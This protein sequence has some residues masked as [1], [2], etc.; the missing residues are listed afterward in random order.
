[1]TAIKAVH[2]AVTRP[3]SLTLVAS[4]SERQSGEFIDKAKEFLERLELKVRKDGKSKH[5]A[6]LPNGSRMVGLP[7]LP[8][9]LRGFTASLLIIDEA[10]QVKELM[11]RTLR[12]TLA[13]QNGDC[14]C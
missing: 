13:V 11:Y 2:R 7:S 3:G 12:P 8:G 5:S 1:M 4:P 9:N 10:A 14:G 6:V